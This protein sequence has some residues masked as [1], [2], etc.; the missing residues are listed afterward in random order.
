MLKT[1]IDAGLRLCRASH[2]NQVEDDWKCFLDS[3][4]G[5]GWVAEKDG[6]VVGTVAFLRYGSSFAWLS[7]MLVDSRERAAG[8][9]SRLLETALD[10]LSGDCVRLDAT[11][12]GEPLYRRFGFV[13]EYELAR[14]VGPAHSLPGSGGTATRL[15]DADLAEVFALDRSV[16]GADRRGLLTSLYERTPELAWAA[17]CDGELLG[18]C[19]GRPGHLYNQ[20]GPIVTKSADVSEELLARCLAAKAGQPMAVDV[21]M[22]P[23]S[24]ESLERIGFQIER[25]FVRMRRGAAV[26]AAQASWQF[27]ITGPEFG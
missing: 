16:F 15:E 21:P 19:F 6:A 27:A 10:A 12:A 25:R 26:Q 9:G 5:G 3:R 14:T 1:D 11:P 18:Y 8:I 20:V 7:M 22:A 4:D 23:A 2:W 24:V 17:R 13:P